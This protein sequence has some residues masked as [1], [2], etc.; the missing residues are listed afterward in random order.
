MTLLW[1]L[2]RLML[3]AAILAALAY[4]VLVLINWNDQPP[5]PTVLE[6]QAALE[7]R[8]A[9]SDRENAYVYM[10]GFGADP[11]DDPTAAGRERI[12]WQREQIAS[13]EF[14]IHS[15]P[16]ADDVVIESG[17]SDTVAALATS[18]KE[19]AVQC[20]DALSA[21]PTSATEWLGTEAWLLTRYTDL[22]TRPGFLN[23]TTM[24][25]E[26]PI[27]PYNLVMEGQRLL[28][29]S[30]WVSA[31][32]GDAARAT[33]LLENDLTFW[34]MVLKNADSLIDKMIAT[35]GIERNFIYGNEVLRAL[36]AS[37]ADASLPE[38]WLKP[39]TDDERSMRRCLIGEWQ[40]MN[41]VTMSLQSDFDSP[42][43]IDED[44]SRLEWRLYLPL[45][46][47]QD[48]SNRHAE[49][50]RQ[51]IELFKVPYADLP[52]AYRRS[53]EL[54]ETDTKP[55]RRAYNIV[56]DWLYSIGQGSLGRYAVR[57]TD[58]EGIRRAALAAATLRA[59]GVATAAVPMSL[60]SMT[61]Q[62]PYRDQPF[63]WDPT[64]ES[65][66]F[67]GLAPGEAGTFR[68]RF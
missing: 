62:N 6:F 57:T 59:R 24:T 15:D 49:L 27:P 58:L 51:E 35:R 48:N 56:G 42:A 40:F 64:A 22:L 9:V 13:E 45:Y 10:F 8:P 12:N 46:Q 14:D 11:A 29:A 61:D 20:A 21:S 7:N 52:D 28:M 33:L 36:H 34:R 43:R 44:V 54:G 55:F 1:R 39:I 30:A 2:N 60:A 17:R 26:S 37:G 63:T 16:L 68:F 65:L 41:H 53:V 18:C 38:S 66:V 19:S 50:L 23:D 32:D 3:Y 67:Q 25:P 4:G 5:S 31:S 47:P